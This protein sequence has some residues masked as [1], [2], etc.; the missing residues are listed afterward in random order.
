MQSGNI[1][2]GTEQPPAALEQSVQDLIAERFGLSIGAVARTGTEL[3]EVVRSDPFAGE[4]LT[5]KLYQVTFLR[6]PAPAE[7][8]GK[9]AA[10]VAPAERFLA[11]DREWYAYH[12]D[13]IARSKLASA[14]AAK[15]SGVLTTTRN[16]TTVR[17]LLEMAGA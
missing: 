8:V 12:P 3:A 7:L 9:L 6:Q 16:W 1:V 4:Q 15:R 11:G 17:T 2:L 13:G 5:E 14:I 10:L